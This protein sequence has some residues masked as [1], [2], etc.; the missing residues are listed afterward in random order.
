M[1]IFDSLIINITLVTLA[2]ISKDKNL[3]ILTSSLVH[4]ICIL[5]GCLAG[6]V[7]YCRIFLYALTW[8][9]GSEF[10]NT[11]VKRKGHLSG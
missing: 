4:K 2:F 7:N 5:A 6:C 10:C 11:V 3:E 9:L 1:N 8:W